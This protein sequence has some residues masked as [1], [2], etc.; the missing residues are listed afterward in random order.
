MPWD[1]VDAHPLT[2][3][4]TGIKGEAKLEAGTLSLLLQSKSDQ[5]EVPGEYLN[6]VIQNHFR[7]IA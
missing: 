7:I 1:V 6:T 4:V 5:H 3:E 2:F